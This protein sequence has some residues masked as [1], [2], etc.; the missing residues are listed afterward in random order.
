MLAATPVDVAPLECE[1]RPY[2]SVLHADPAK[3]AK[4]NLPLG[5][6]L[7]LCKSPT[8]G[9]QVLTVPDSGG[10]EMCVF[11][12]FGI[13]AKEPEV[14]TTKMRT[15]VGKALADKKCPPL[16]YS[17]HSY[18][19][20]DYF[21]LSDNVPL[22]NAFAVKARVEKTGL[23]FLKDEQKEQ[24]QPKDGRPAVD[25]GTT[26]LGV[27][28][29]AAAPMNDCRKNASLLAGRY[30]ACYRVEVYN[31]A[32]RGGWNVLVALNT[33]REYNIIESAY[34]PGPQPSSKR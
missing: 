8:E 15:G 10:T 16:D 18:P 34:K 23:A 9:S 19:G 33:K 5:S 17:Q 12:E 30:A 11:Y 24:K 14:Q 1:M 7:R 26:A 21:F 6:T 3:K 13:N 28:S 25:F 29:I 22:P 32:I 2:M 31:K 4:V 27:A 20:K